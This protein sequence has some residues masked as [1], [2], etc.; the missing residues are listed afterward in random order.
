MAAPDR[1][2]EGDGLA[3]VQVRG[4]VLTVRRVDAYV[5]MTVVAPAIATRF[6]PGQFV[7]IAV[8][9]PS[10]GMLARRTF[11]VHDVRPDH[12]GTVEFVFL[13]REP[14]TEWLADCRSRDVLDIV[15]P[16][17]R[18]F[19]VPRDPASCMLVGVGAGAAPLFSLAARLAER[20]CP[21]DFLLGAESSERVF[22]ALTAG[23]TGRSAIITTTD[24]TMGTRG[25]VVDLLPTVVQRAKTDVIYASAPLPVLRAVSV[26]AGRYAIPVQALVSEPAMVCGTG[27]CMGCVLPAVGTDG[28]TRMVRACVDGPVFRGDLV[29]WDDVGT[30]PFDAL[31]APGWKPRGGAAATGAMPALSDA[32]EGRQHAG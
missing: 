15:G 17:G 22:G 7:A 30:I 27:L 1:D 32:P 4:T 9:G 31:G 11:S 18:P 10:S 24:G 6:R 26:L 16:L 21:A 23:R 28:I 12:G 8:G 2:R 3:P 29:R 25:S 13:P 5:A 19:P 14:G 20:G